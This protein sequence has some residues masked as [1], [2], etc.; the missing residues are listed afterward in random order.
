MPRD[1]VL[2]TP[3]PFSGDLN[4]SKGFLLQC[5][6]VFG[7]SPQSF[8][9]DANK[10]SYVIGLLRDKA[11]RRHP[12]LFQRFGGTQDPRQTGWT[13]EDGSSQD[14]GSVGLANP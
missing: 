7:R 13:G 2:P 6:L 10:I 12:D 1:V 5:S 4:K 14:Q 3:E 8:P 11:L 9:D